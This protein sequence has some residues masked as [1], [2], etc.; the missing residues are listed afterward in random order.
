MGKSILTNIKQVLLIVFSV[1]L[2]LYLSERIEEGKNEKEAELLLSK[3]KSEIDDNKKVLE[4]WVP[5]HK[6]IVNRLD[7]LTADEAFVRRF[8]DNQSTLFSEVIIKGTLMGAM[9]S[10]DAWDIAKSHPLIVH[11]EYEVLLALS[12]VYNQQALT[13]ASV[14]K[15]MEILLSVDFNSQAKAKSNLLAFKNQMHEILSREEQLLYFLQESD[16]ALKSKSK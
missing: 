12:K 6:E 9:P 16:K 10:S 4:Y 11:F 14:P 13:Y 15:I 7:S 2:G 5:Y 1:V 3:L 8:V